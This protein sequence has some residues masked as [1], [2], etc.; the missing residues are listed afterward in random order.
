MAHALVAGTEIGTGDGVVEGV[1]VGI[2]VSLDDSVD[3]G[4][5]EDVVDSVGT[6]EVGGLEDN[7]DVSVPLQAKTTRARYPRAVP[8]TTITLS[9]R[10]SR[11]ENSLGSSFSEVVIFVFASQ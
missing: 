8:P 2:G 10:N 6:V 1:I 5:V 7:I 3:S 4:V 11:L 9:F